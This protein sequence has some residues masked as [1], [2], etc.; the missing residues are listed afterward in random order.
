MNRVVLST[1]AALFL[2]GGSIFLY[3]HVSLGMAL[4]PDPSA[5]VWRIDFGMTVRGDGRPAQIELAIPESDE[6]QNVLDEES[7][8]DGLALRI[9]DDEKGRRAIWSGRIDGT[10]H[11]AYGVRIH[12]PR[13]EV[14]IDAERVGLV[15]A[16]RGRRPA[17]KPS[18]EVQSLLK[19]L[20]MADGE[21]PEAIIASSFS[22]VVHDIET[23]ANGSDDPRIVLRT[24]EGSNEGKTRLLLDLLRG[25]GVES[26]LASGVRLRSR[27]QSWI[28]RFVEAAADGRAVPL[29]V[30]SERPNDFPANFL[31]LK[32]GEGEVLQTQGLQASSFDVSVLRETLPPDEM[33]AFVAPHNPFWRAISLYRL[34]IETRRIL[35]ILLV[36]PLAALVAAG[37]RNLVGV[38]TFGTFMPLLLAL[39]LYETNVVIGVLL[40]AVCLAVGVFGRLLLDRLRLLFVPRICLLLS[41]V[42][43]TV[44]SLAQIG[45]AWGGRELMGGLLFPIVI[46]AM[47]IERISVNTMEEGMRSTAQLLI[48][49]F[50]LSALVYPLFRSAGLGHLFLGF[51][52]LIFCVMACL[53]LMGGYTGYRVA[54]LVRFRSLLD[55]PEPGDAGPGSRA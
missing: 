29:I 47:L 32:R 43:L 23:A 12:I 36:I 37:Y 6:R 13:A 41:L 21:D 55:A 18:P 17:P 51:P 14:E 46:L 11:L 3:K 9:V 40:V 1:A 16:P 7:I 8:D 26:R 39:S 38:R 10:R 53:V 22:F 31:L 25:A 45:Y 52:E 48:G 28:E 20:G 2:L 33:A 15:P 54:E 35:S 4:W 49:S 30:S 24:R 34:P 50:G 19:E 42:I 5:R 27:G 44:T